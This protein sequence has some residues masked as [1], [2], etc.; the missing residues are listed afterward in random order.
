[1]NKDRGIKVGDL[2]N[3]LEGARK[4]GLVTEII[5]MPWDN[6]LAGRNP[7]NET[8]KHAKILWR[9]NTSRSYKLSHLEPMDIKEFKP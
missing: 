5:D 6:L 2:V 8:I 7:R 9:D 4:A 3:E 1:M